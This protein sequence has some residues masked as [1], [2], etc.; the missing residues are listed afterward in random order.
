MAKVD[1]LA[2]RQQR[3][4]IVFDP[5]GIRVLGQPEAIRE[6]RHMRVDDDARRNPKRGAEH[7]VGRLPPDAVQIDQLFQRLWNIAVVTFDELAAAGLNVLR[8]VA[9]ETGR[10]DGLFE[11]LDR[12]VRVVGGGAV[13]LEQIARD[14]VHADV[15]TLGR[16]DYGDEQFERRVEVQ[17]ALGVAVKLRQSSGRFTR[18]AFS[19][20]I[21]GHP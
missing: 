1:P 19:C 9:I 21:D 7:D 3:R 2:L 10:T 13:A 16:Q 5:H 18:A 4:Q 14:D 8:F 20:C 17:G 12:R 15:G 6:P 11:F